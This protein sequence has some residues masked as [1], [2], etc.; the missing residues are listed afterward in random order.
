MRRH[1]K[2][3]IKHDRQNQKSHAPHQS[4]RRPDLREIL[5]RQARLRTPAARRPRRRSRKSSGRKS[6]P[7]RRRRFPR[8]QRNR[9]HTPLHAPFHVELRHRSRHVS[10][11]LLHHEVQSARQRIRRSPR[12]YRH[13]TSLPAARTFPRLP[14]NSATPRKMSSRNHRHG[15]HH[16]CNLP[17]AHRAK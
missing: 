16:A 8:S 7:R 6:S 11:R 1:Y 12:R 5:A 13:R 3:Q 14:Q 9:S 4:E 17:P 15:L 10:A 2:D